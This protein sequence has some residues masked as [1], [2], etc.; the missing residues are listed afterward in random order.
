[1]C[2]ECDTP[3]CVKPMHLFAGT[4]ADNMTDMSSKGRWGNQYRKGDGTPNPDV[5]LNAERECELDGCANPV[6]AKD[7]CRKHYQQIWK[8][9]RKDQSDERS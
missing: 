3:L 7:L 4:H 8:Q 1:M 5:V 9:I 2:H 6:L